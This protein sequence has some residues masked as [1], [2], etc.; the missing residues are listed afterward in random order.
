MS[1]L[2][3]PITDTDDWTL[4]NLQGAGWM[5]A[6]G[7]MYAGDDC[8]WSTRHH[9]GLVTGCM[10]AIGVK[11]IDCWHV[12]VCWINVIVGLSGYNDA[13]CRTKL[14]VTSL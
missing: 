12:V 13:H 8:N 2:M 10:F 7:V 3:L 5:I 9:I 11:N 6:T 1:Y 14:R 4:M